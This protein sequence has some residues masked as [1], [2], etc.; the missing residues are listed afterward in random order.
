MSNL[1]IIENRDLQNLRESFNI[2]LEKF[3]LAQDIKEK[4]KE[5]YKKALK[6]FF[7][8]L[9]EDN[10][11][12]LTREDIIAYKKSLKDKNLSAYTISTYITAIRKFFEW[13]ESIK[14]YP[15]ISKGIKGT[16]KPRGFRKDTLTVEQVKRILKSIDCS[17]LQGKRDFA[18]INLLVRTGLRTIELIRTDI[19]DIRQEGGEAILYIHGKGRDCKDDM[20]L[21]TEE[22]LRPITTYLSERKTIKDKEPLFLS[23]SDRNKNQRLTTRSV[24]R[25]VKTYLR[26]IGLNNESLTTHSFRHTAVTLSLLGGATIHESQ[27]FARHANINATLA[28]AHNID[29]IDKAPERKIDIMLASVN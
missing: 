6:Q 1:T 9:N 15:N 8:Y 22:T 20:V 18:I 16:K 14:L 29:R 27:I 13:T 4:S 25:I 24:S 12:S 7:G 21:L 5:T 3:L 2:L 26:K 17:V 11:T 19:E 28:Y 10:I 23:I